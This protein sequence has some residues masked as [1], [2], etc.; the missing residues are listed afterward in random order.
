[1]YGPPRSLPHATCSF[2]VSPA[3]SEMSPL[4]PGLIAKI[5]WIGRFPLDDER[6]VAA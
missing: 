4:A 3:F 5:G 6:Q 1:M 2:F